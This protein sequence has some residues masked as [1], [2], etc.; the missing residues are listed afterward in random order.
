MDCYVV[1]QTTIQKRF[2]YS[3]FR[4]SFIFIGKVDK[5]L[6][7][8][9]MIYCCENRN[10]SFIAVEIERFNPDVAA[11]YKELCQESCFR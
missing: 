5:F 11:V 2:T 4:V 8:R 7:T 1:K 10:L 3:N 9:V 6:I